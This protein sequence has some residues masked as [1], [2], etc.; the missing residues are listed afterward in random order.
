M[1]TYAYIL[2]LLFTTTTFATSTPQDATTFGTTAPLATAKETVT[3]TFFAGT[4]ATTH[5]NYGT[6]PYAS[7]LTATTTKT[8]TTTTR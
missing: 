3:T 1:K 5:A 4:R 6:T 8:F 7:T 2:P